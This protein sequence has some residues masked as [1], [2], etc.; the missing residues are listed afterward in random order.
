MLDLQR[1]RLLAELHRRGTIAAVA[2][3]LSYS[4][5]TVSHQLS[6]LQREA[7]ATLFE[8]DGRR[9]RFTEAAHVLARHADAILERVERA[10][11]EVAAAAGAVTGVVR[12][13]AFQTAARLLAP[14]LADLARQHPGLRLETQISEPDYTLQALERREFDLAVIDEY[15]S[16][17]RPRPGG[18]AFEELHVENVRLVVPSDHPCARLPSV[19]L[20]DLESEI[21]AGGPPD[22]SHG[23]MVRDVCRRHGFAPDLRHQSSDALSLL[24]LIASGQA[25]TL[26]AD[27]ARPE[28]EPGVAAVTVAGP[29]VVRRVLTAVREGSLARPAL[30]AVRDG[31]ARAVRAPSQ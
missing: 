7:G 15:E 10:E 9:L 27:L 29:P 11:A 23:R 12:I 13:G 2:E 24:A 26:L 20:N 4:P 3:A 30:R 1:L 21:W 18:L 19:S 28:R 6:E 22:T 25:V 8:R 17:R 31:L 5:S 16:S 14:A